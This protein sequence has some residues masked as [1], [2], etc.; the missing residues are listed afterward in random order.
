MIDTH[1]HLDLYPKPMQIAHQANDAGVLTICVTNLPSAFAEAQI[2]LRSLRHI[3][4]ALGLHPLLADHHVHER[5]A[6]QDYTDKTSY[7]GEVGLDFSR[8]GYATRDTQVE[9]LQFIL[10]LLHD[11]PKFIS[12]HSRRAERVMLDMLKH[13]KRSPVVF[14]WYSGPL[15]VLDAALQE[16]HYFSLNPA[17]IRSENGQKIAAH[18]LPNR[19]LTETDGPFVK[20]GSRS[21]IPQDV[22]KVEIYLAKLWRKEPQEV[23]HQIQANLMELL[24]PLLPI[25]DAISSSEGTHSK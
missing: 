2:R 5:P 3:R 9:S 7:I 16:G 18:L 17:M 23:F 15:G 12:L 6:F 8:E 24:R 22:H 25:R 20:I 13:A 21:A 4:V 14:H 19:V 1:C 10:E 11:K